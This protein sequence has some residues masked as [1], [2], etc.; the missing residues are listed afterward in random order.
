VKIVA[1]RRAVAALVSLVAL[2]FLSACGGEPAA[3]G[4]PSGGGA[5]GFPVT[6]THKY[7]EATITAPPKRVISLGY[8]DQDTILALGVVPVAIREFT[9]NQPSATWPWARDRLQGQQP[10]VLPVSGIGPETLAGLQP[11]LIVAVSA[12]LTKEDYDLYSRIAPVIAQ[13]AQYV[14]YGTPWPDA[15]RLVGQALG[16]STEAEKIIGDLQ[17]RIRQVAAANPGLAGRS[18]AG[19]R[20]SSNDSASYFVWG[21]QDLRARFFTDLGM[22]VP[23]TFAR[24]AGDRFYAEVSTEQLGLLDQSDVVALITAGAAERAAFTGLPGYGRLEAVQG[25][26][27]VTFDDQES[28]ALSFSSVLSLPQLL[29]TVP[30]KLGVAVAGQAPAAG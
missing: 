29:E 27:L 20:P 22:T 5:P 14:D 2:L 26:R 9:G 6:I 16:K 7:G 18:I 13:P 30:A 24:L 19:V 28:A 23:P 3:P 4:A 15:T 10:Q 8:T 12:G 1:P 17:A 21:P 25:R 11:D